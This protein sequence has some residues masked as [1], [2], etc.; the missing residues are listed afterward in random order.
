MALDRWIAVIFL[1]ISIVY[2]YAAYGY[3]LLPFERNMS[4]LPNT[5]PMV[6]SVAGAIFSLIIILVPGIGFG[7]K[8]SGDP[9]N[10]SD[11]RNFRWGQATGLI[12][13][14]LLFALALRPLGFIASSIV[15]LVGAG[16]I[17]G[18][19]K[20]YIMVPVALLGSGMLWYLVQEMLGIFLRPLPWFLS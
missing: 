10:T 3:P 9:D 1:M 7:V 19:R 11:T 4:F 8:E 17:L 15:F 5:M 16:W 6:L 20:L 14:M 12:V 13:A 18:E 2:G